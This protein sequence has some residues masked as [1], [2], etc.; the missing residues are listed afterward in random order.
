LI[1]KVYN[2]RITFFMFIPQLKKTK[3][4]FLYL[5]IFVFVLF[6]PSITNA[7]DSDQ[8]NC[9]KSWKIV[10]LG[11]STAFGTGASNNDSS[12]TGR[13]NKYIKRKNATTQLY[14]LGI[15]GYRTYQNLRPDGY[16][17]PL[18]RPVP[19][20]GF[21]ITAALALQPDAIIINMPSNDAVS[22]YTLLEQKANFE[23][24]IRIADSAKIPV[25]VTTTQ[26]RNLLTTD[27]MQNLKDM[28]Q[29]VLDRFGSKAI[30][31]WDGL[32]NTDGTIASAYF[33]DN[34]HVND[35]GHEV[36]YKRLLQSCI[37]DTL[38][39]RQNGILL[40]NAGLDTTINLPTTSFSLQGTA[41]SS[42]GTITNINWKKIAGPSSGLLIDSTSLTSSY[43]NATNGIYFFELKV[44]DSKLI[45]LRDTI[46]VEVK[47]T[48]S[49]TDTTSLKLAA[50]SGNLPISWNGIAI[51]TAGNYS[52]LLTNQFGCDSLVK[53]QLSIISGSVAVNIKCF[54]EGFFNS[55]TNSLNPKLYNVGLSPDSEDVDTV[56][57]QLWKRNNLEGINPDFSAKG[58]LKKDGMLVVKFPNSVINKYFY[59]T[60]KNKTSIETWSADSIIINNGLYFDFTNN[61]LKSYGDGINLP[62]KN[63]AQKKYALYSGDVNQDGG[64]DLFDIQN[65]ENKANLFNFGYQDAD[66]NGDGVVDLIDLQIIENNLSLFLFLAR[67]FL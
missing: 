66:C 5:I 63:V 56:L 40:V 58:I 59:L 43:T 20:V 64:I 53:L 10:V 14:N 7:A 22:N 11:S 12:W 28:R 17:P 1:A 48:S 27:Q 54:S 47:C 60:L 65:A 6:F 2:K 46:K 4:F 57:V 21:N 33:Y 67:P 35:K 49:S 25:W 34:V 26:P 3:L 30:N 16:L 9:N 36:F 41:S 50:C 45:E 13:F 62:T 61:P 32:A 42:K 51:N 31:F 23:E 19:S 37:L 52:K 8:V 15:P 24:A 55:S 29:W 44:K 18:N 39:N 38:C